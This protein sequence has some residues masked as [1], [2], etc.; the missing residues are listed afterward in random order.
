MGI[1]VTNAWLAG[2]GVVTTLVGYSLYGWSLHD[3]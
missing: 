2:V 1:I 3:D